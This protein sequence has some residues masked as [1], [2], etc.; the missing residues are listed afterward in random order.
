MDIERN[1]V[2]GSERLR[3]R[4]IRGD[5]C[6]KGRTWHVGSKPSGNS[7]DG[8]KD[9]AGNVW[10]WTSSKSNDR[11]MV[12]GGSWYFDDPQYFRASYRNHAS[13]PTSRYFH[14]GSRCARTAAGTK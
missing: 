8:V 9:M 3:A 4:G 13:V 7:R 11:R 10:E 6:G 5:G 14:V 2:P 1:P 12:R